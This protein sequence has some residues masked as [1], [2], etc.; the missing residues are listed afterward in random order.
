MVKIT[1]TYSISASNVDR[2]KASGLNAS[3]LIDNLLDEYF[4]N[5]IEGSQAIKNKLAETE[6][7]IAK[8]I[9]V[10]DSLKTRLLKAEQEERNT[11]GSGVKFYVE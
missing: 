9:R 6:N 7:E 1:R 10:M 8:N 4:E 3:E 5:S 11:T 2:L